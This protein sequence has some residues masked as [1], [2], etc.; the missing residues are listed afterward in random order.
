MLIANMKSAKVVSIEYVG[1]DNIVAKKLAAINPNF[2]STPT[3]IARDLTIEGEIVSAGLIEIEG[4]IKGT[5]RGNSVILR[6]NGFVEGNIIAESLSVRGTFDG[7]IRA[8]NIDISSKAKVTG[9][10]IYG[11]L[12]VEDGACIDG[13][14]KKIS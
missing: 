9:E 1:N 10:I 7:Q 4:R 8:K 11:S 12:S 3:I 14:F 5:I 2:K 13:S 6:E